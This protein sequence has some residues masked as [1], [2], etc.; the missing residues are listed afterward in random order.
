MFKIR[1]LGPVRLYIMEYKGHCRSREKNNMG[2]EEYICHQ[3][4][5]DLFHTFTGK[6]T[7]EIFSDVKNSKICMIRVALL[8]HNIVS[9]VQ[10]CHE[11]LLAPR[12]HP[13]STAYTLDSIQIRLSKTQSFSLRE[14]L[15][16]FLSKIL[17]ITVSDNILF[18]IVIVSL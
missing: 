12:R 18:F 14:R 13:G 8:Y 4:N 17:V 7:P 6:K 9:W 16:F 3:K 15:A 2:S 11:F 5:S 10:T 1:L